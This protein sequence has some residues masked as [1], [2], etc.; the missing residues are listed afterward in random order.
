MNVTEQLEE[1]ISLDPTVGKDETV[2]VVSSGVDSELLRTVKAL[3]G[4]TVIVQD[5]LPKSKV[6]VVGGRQPGKTNTVRDIY[7]RCLQQK[8]F[9]VKPRRNKSDRKRD[10]KNRW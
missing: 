6:A 7:Q 9:T 3:E 5:E 2:V 8:Q 1:I 10:K 4:V